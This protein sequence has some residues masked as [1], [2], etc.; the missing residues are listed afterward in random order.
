MAVKLNI[1]IENYYNS[2]E[3]FEYIGILTNDLFKIRKGRPNIL[4]KNRKS[5]FIFTDGDLLNKVADCLGIEIYIKDTKKD[6]C[7]K[8][9]EELLFLEKYSTGKDKLTYIIISTDNPLYSFPYNLED[10]Q[11]Y[12]IEK[13]KETIKLELEIL[14]KINKIK[15]DNMNVITYTIEIANNIYMN[16]Y[17]GFLNSLGFKLLGKKWIVHIE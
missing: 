9:E 16:E 11:K 15:V 8:I 17:T 4:F 1:S 13:L 2:K 5:N 3:E 7:K 12:T 10:R 6:I 14:E